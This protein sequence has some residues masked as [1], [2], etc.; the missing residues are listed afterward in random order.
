MKKIKKEKEVNLYDLSC[1]DNSND[2]VEMNALSKISSSYMK[3][4]MP[5]I[6]LITK[7][8]DKIATINETIMKLTESLTAVIQP[9]LERISEIESS[10]TP[11][12]SELAKSIENIKKNPDSVFNWI[13]FSESLTRYFWLPP[14]SMTSE[15][16]M[17]LLK[18]VKNEEEMD[19]EL[20]QYFTDEI[21][22]NLVNEII[23]KSQDKHKTIMKQ[24]RFSYKKGF[25]AL[26]NTG[27]FSVIDSLCSF[28]VI[29]PKKNTYRIDLFKPIFEKEAKESDNYDSILILSMINENINTLYSPKKKTHKQ[30]RRP[31]S[32]HGVSFS[33]NKIDSIMLFHTVYYLLLLT[34][35]YSNYRKN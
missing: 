6:E 8:I 13:D 1:Q 20:E 29:N 14:Y 28:F 12:F 32:Q 17:E 22:D 18:N 9:V 16:L 23:D 21:V 15:Q 11:F 33:N 31:L 30:A 24:I 25:Y 34:K 27:L 4:M 2:F 19:I 26:V 7:N 5:S 3:Q 10:I 35:T